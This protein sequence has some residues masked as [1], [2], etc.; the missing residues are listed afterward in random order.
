MTIYRIQYN[1]ETGNSF[2]SHEETDIL[3][4]KWENLEIAKQNLQRIK[5]H[6]EFYC[7]F[8]NEKEAQTKDWFVEKY[9]YCLKLQ[10]DNGNFAQ[11]A[12]PW[13]G[14]FERLNWVEIIIETP[15]ISDM[16]IEF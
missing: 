3:E 11:I 12:A 8:L 15:E 14:Y 13:C 4:F 7:H 16:R 6:R 9:K 5:E 1:Y 10:A 2:G